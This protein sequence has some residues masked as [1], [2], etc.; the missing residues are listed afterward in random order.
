MVHM[1]TDPVCGMSIEADT[2]PASAEFEGQ[3]YFFC[4]RGCREDFVSEPGHYL[5]QARA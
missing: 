2:A 1:A 4:A 5:Q 3:T